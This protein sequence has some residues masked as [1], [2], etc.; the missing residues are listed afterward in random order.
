MANYRF[1]LASQALHEFIWNEYCDWYVELSKPILWDEEANPDQAQATRRVLLTVL[2]KSLR[3]LHPFMPF[4]TE[5]VWQ[6][7]APLLS[8]EGDSIMLQPYPVYDVANVDQE[9]E[10]NID[11]LKGVIIAIRNIRGEMN[12]SPARSIPV[13]LRSSSESDRQRLEGYRPYLQKL[14]RLDSIEYLASSAE[15]PAAATQLHGDLEILVPLAG[16]IDVEA[17]CARLNKEI[18]KLEGGLKAVSGKLGNTKFVDN[19]PQAVVAREREKEQ[20]MSGALKALREKLEQLQ[21]L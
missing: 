16:L 12:I 9:A 20:Q 21:V 5:E 19:A 10:A 7:V 8:I 2:E 18:S 11:W 14:A 3:L 17:E 13:L 4:L 6:R 15:A 1:D